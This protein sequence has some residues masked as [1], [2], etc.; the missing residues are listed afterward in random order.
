[1]RIQQIKRF[2]L[3]LGLLFA[4]VWVLG[5]GIQ[6]RANYTLD[7]LVALGLK[8]NPSVLASFHEAAAQEAAYQ[9]SKRLFN[10]ELEFSLGKGQSHY[11]LEERG[12]HG[13]SVTQPLENPFKR[14]FRVQIFRRAWEEASQRFELSSLE[15]VSEIKVGFYT[16][17]FL[18]QKEELL[19][20]TE[21][22]VQE[23]YALI[24]KRAELGEVKPL[25]AIKLRVEALKARKELNALQAERELARQNLNKLLGNNLPQD[26]TL[27]GT[28]DYQP[29]ALAEEDK[30]LAGAL[31]SHPYVLASQLQLERARSQ[32]SYVKWQRL[33]D[34][35]L[36]GFSHSE[37]DGTNRGVGVTL[38]IPLWNFKGRELVEAENL[39]R[40]SEQDLISARLDL[41]EEIRSR[42]RQVKLAEETLAIFS[43]G[44]L[45]QA[46]ESL[47]IARI[48]Y[49]QGEIS[50]L[51]FLD[52]QRTYNSIMEDY[53]Q[54]LLSWNAE[55]A[56]LE[57]ALGDRIQ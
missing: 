21:R 9:A 16:L 48:S 28:L 6:E 5:E 18:Q 20:R 42:L 46:E 55:K 11:G 12:T 15:L 39:S 45:R 43:D 30:L 3:G 25:E 35:A 49:E 13:F 52:S 7:E 53:Y 23:T 4:G 31:S 24:Q 36:K 1:M 50:L 41:A 14:R 54:A 38:D 22:S 26:Y 57:K 34:L 27:T 29:L 40:K 33:P 19:Q 8:H 51:D 47:K 10:P 17:L 2:V 37:L 32:I 44:L 56:A